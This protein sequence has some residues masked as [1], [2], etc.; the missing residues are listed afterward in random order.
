VLSVDHTNLTAL[1]KQ[2][3]HL[4]QLSHISFSNNQIRKIPKALLNLPQL[5]LIEL[6]HNP[7]TS[8]CLKTSYQ[9]NDLG[10]RKLVV[11]L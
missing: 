8:L 10:K 2:L 6:D 5:S 3:K 9:R 11:V 1:P 4:K 7:L